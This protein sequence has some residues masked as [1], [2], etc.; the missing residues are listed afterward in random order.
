MCPLWAIGI[1]QQSSVAPLLSPGAPPGRASE[2]G[3]ARRPRVSD[4]VTADPTRVHPQIHSFGDSRDLPRA[5]HDFLIVCI[6]FTK[7]CFLGT[8]FRWW[9]ASKSKTG[10]L[11]ESR[12]LAWSFVEIA[13]PA[14][15]VDR[16]VAARLART[17]RL[18]RRALFVSRWCLLVGRL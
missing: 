12:F 9:A 1:A 2:S 15:F 8:P 10:P 18:S 4:R 17:R 11:L 13:F 5:I 3:L 6:S 16:A 14:R 7:A